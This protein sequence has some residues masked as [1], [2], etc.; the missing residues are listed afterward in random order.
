MD[1]ID[2]DLQVSCIIIHHQ[3]ELCL[4]WPAN[5]QVTCTPNDWGTVAFEGII[6]APTKLSLDQQNRMPRT[7]QNK[8]VNKTLLLEQLRVVIQRFARPKSLNEA[9]VKSIDDGERNIRSVCACRWR[10]AT[11]PTHVLEGH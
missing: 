11:I 4:S 5:R 7:Q 6:P 2:R 3:R 9:V 8:K 1:T 10:R